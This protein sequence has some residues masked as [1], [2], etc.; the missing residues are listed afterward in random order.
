[1]RKNKPKTPPTGMY[2]MWSR[3]QKRFIFGIQEPSKTKARKA[4]E[5]EIGPFNTHYFYPKAIVEGHADLMLRNGLG[6]ELKT[7]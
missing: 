5:K 2:G 7:K 6:K 4:L 3:A 1:M